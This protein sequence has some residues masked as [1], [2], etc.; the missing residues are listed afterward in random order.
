MRNAEYCRGEGKRASLPF[1]L[2]ATPA[3]AEVQLKC[4]KR[5]ICDQF[6][7]SAAPLWKGERYSHDRIRVAYLSSDL[8]DHPTAQLMAG[9][10]EQHDKS[11]FETFA[12]SLSAPA[13]E[14]DATAVEAIVRSFHRRRLNKRPG[15]SRRHTSL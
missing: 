4:A 1:Q 13:R 7:A 11:R 14:R 8:R 10:F 12:I 5:Y 15:R 3:S 9:Q 6:P 2:L